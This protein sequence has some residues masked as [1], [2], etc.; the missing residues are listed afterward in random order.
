M[1]GYKNFVT[2][3]VLTAADVQDYLMDQS[4]MVFGGTAARGSAIASPTEG[5][6]TY[7]SDTDKVQV[8]NGTAWTDVGRVGAAVLSNTPT[9]TYSSGGTA[10]AYYE[11]TASG[12]ATVTTAGV[13]D[14]LLVGGGGGG[15][16]GTFGVNYGAGA[17]GGTSR[18]ISNV[19]LP[20]GSNTVVI[21]AGG[22]AGD[23][24]RGG[25][26]SLAGYSVS[27]GAST[28]GARIGGFNA[29]FV[30]F[31]TSTGNN[32]GGG[33][34]AGASATSTAGG[35]GASFSI[36]GTSVT[37]G[38]GGG[39]SGS[40]GGSGGGG[41]GSSGGAGTS[42]TTNRGGGGGGGAGSN[43]NGGSGI[44]IIRVRT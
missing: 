31:F 15:G 6:V 17:G 30:G 36:S 10:Y 7:L 1:G 21:G 16:G 29:D 26:T 38:G 13:V 11:F 3:Q 41:A 18:Q 5:M 19:Y 2:G 24:V 32:A 12:T 27:G 40:A 22:S 42:G 20:S 9:G 37:Y 43:S 34:G 23:G 8:Y 33:G 4:V 44:V 39:S 28:G 14:V 25:T 35:S